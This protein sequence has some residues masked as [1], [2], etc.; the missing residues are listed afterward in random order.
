MRICVCVCMRVC[1]RDVCVCVC[2]CV[3]GVCGCAELLVR[4]TPVTRC[5]IHRLSH[6][7][8]GNPQ[9]HDVCYTISRTPTAAR[10][11][12]RAGLHDDVPDWMTTSIAQPT[13]LG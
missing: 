7:M 10:V 12:T 6:Y 1:V 2:V 4:Y 9:L 5:L 3:R 8:S 11:E 13:F